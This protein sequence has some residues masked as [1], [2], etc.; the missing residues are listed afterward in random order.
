MRAKLVIIPLIAL[1]LFSVSFS[2]QAYSHSGDVLNSGASPAPTIDGVIGV[3]EWANAGTLPITVNLP[4]G[5][6]AAGTLYAMNDNTNIYFAMSVPRTALEQQDT[7]FSVRLDQVHGTGFGDN[8]DDI[9][10]IST[11]GFFDDV[12]TNLPPCPAGNPP[13][14]CGPKDVDVTP[15]G[16][17]DG[18]GAVTNDG[19]NTMWELSHPLSSGD[20]YDIS[21][22]TTDVVGFSI[23][24]SLNSN[25]APGSTSFPALATGMDLL[26]GI[27]ETT[28]IDIKPGSDPNSINPTNRGVIPVAILGSDTFDVLDVDV[29]TLAFGPSGASIAHKNA[30]LADVND[31]GLTDLVSHYRTEETGIAFGDTEACVT[32]ET[33]DGTPF[34]GCDDIRTVPN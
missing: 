34:E 19:T 33:L 14:F 26:L 4:E 11:S 24:I 22:T 9:V 18:S 32:G 23:S 29:T 2:Y 10:V 16:T 31:D 13:G 7:I 17:T 1:V 3:A 15:P 25:L 30:H 6:T 20:T 12:R 27:V 5:G 21:V 28:E 8:N